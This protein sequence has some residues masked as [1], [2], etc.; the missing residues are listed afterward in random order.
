MLKMKAFPG[1]AYKRNPLAGGGRVPV[2]RNPKK[3]RVKKA[4]NALLALPVGKCAVLLP[5]AGA[6][7][8]M[9]PSSSN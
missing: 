4:N 1:D 9:L 6:L 2:G 7:V 8:L 5:C 3:V